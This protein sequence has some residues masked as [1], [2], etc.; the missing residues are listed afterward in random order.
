VRVSSARSSIESGDRSSSCNAYDT[1]SLELNG[2]LADM[3]AKGCT[4]AVME[5]GRRTRFA[6]KRGGRC[7]LEGR[8]LHQSHTGSSGLPRSMDAYLQAKRILF[9]TLDPAATAVTN[10]DDP[11]GDTI[12][13]GTPARVLSYGTRP[14]ANVRAADITLGVRG[15]SFTMTAAGM[16]RTVTSPLTGQ[17]TSPTSLQRAAWA[18]R[19]AFPGKAIRAGIASVRSVRGRSSRWSPRRGGPRSWTTRTRRT[20]WKM[21]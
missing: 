18:S 20:H 3:V 10:A 13:E 21:F 15:S 11:Y 1:G 8:R 7:A 19:L 5:V 9:R 14:V 12:V 16:S 17:S 6:M 4:A 2:L